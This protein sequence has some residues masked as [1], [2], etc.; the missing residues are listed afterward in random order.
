MYSQTTKVINASG[1]HARPASLFVKEAKAFASRICIQ[2]LRTPAEKPAN[3]KSIISVLA[4]GMAQGTDVEI[5]A[6]GPDEESA[7]NALIALIDSGF[8]E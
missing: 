3:A 4:L 7:V 8:G 6:D 1:L 5:T 2:N